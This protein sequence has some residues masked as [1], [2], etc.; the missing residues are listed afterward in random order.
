MTFECAELGERINQNFKAGRLEL[1][2]CEHLA[3]LCQL[4]PGIYVTI[5]KIVRFAGPLRQMMS[6]LQF[7]D[8]KLHLEWS[9]QCDDEMKYTAIGIIIKSFIKFDLLIDPAA[10]QLRWQFQLKAI[11][12][13]V[14]ITRWGQNRVWTII[15]WSHGDVA[16]FAQNLDS[17]T[18]SHPLS[19]EDYIGD[20]EQYLSDRFRLIDSL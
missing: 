18:P 7:L 2:N 1:V 3:L 11:E 15:S 12:Q 19:K 14:P 9:Q 4:P 6:F 13:G 10:C 20:I 16:S 17:D 5:V 8:S